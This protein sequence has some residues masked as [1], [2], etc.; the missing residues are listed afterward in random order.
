[1]KSVATILILI[2]G[3]GVMPGAAWALPDYWGPAADRSIITTAAQVLSQMNDIPL[4]TYLRQVEQGAQVSAIE[5]SRLIPKADQDL[6]SAIS[7]ERSLLHAMR[8]ARI[9][10]Y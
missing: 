10:P 6:V 9:D 5:V 2:C 3:I 7:M 4:A 8:K 1:M